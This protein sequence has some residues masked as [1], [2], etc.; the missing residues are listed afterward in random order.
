[1]KNFIFKKAKLSH[2]G[3]KSNTKNRP[4]K[5][6]FLGLAMIGIAA[7]MSP[8]TAEA[9]SNC[10]RYINHTQSYESC[11]I[12]QLP[13]RINTSATKVQLNITNYKTGRTYSD[14][15]TVFYIAGR[16]YN[17]SWKIYR[18]IPEHKF[19]QEVAK[20][21]SPERMIAQM[22]EYEKDLRFERRERRYHNIDELADD[23]GQSKKDSHIL[24]VIWDYNKAQKRNQNKIKWLR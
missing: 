5:N 4:F 17:N 12:S 7:S 15:T 6:L 23:I 16:D 10:G 1:M 9:S 2:K 13:K 3:G 19:T 22:A 20:N 21:L 11:V 14:R 8:T 24:H 18:A